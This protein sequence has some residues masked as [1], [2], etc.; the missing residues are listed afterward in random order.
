MHIR[1]LFLPNLI[2]SIALLGC[3]KGDTLSSRQDMPIVV[4][5]VANEEPKS[6]D[7]PFALAQE[8]RLL[9]FKKSNAVEKEL[10]VLPTM[11]IKTFNVAAYAEYEDGWLVASGRGEWGGVVFW[12]D[13][14]GFKVIRDDDY[15]YP[16][17]L[18][19][20]DDTLLLLQGMSHLSIEDG[21]LLEISRNK[22]GTFSTRAYP[23]DGYPTGFVKENG[24]WTIPV[25][26][27]GRYLLLSEL[28]SGKPKFY[29]SDKKE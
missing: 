15:A 12:M 29:M 8:I 23:I 9:K 24:R 3:D 21:H 20:E 28:K 1:K 19:K 13:N 4:T 6:A 11:K 27:S 26:S 5:V 25:G 16:I 7:V 14:E 18:I 22:D 2:L 10:G 17:D